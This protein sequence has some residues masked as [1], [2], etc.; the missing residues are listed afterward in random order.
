MCHEEYVINWLGKFIANIVYFGILREKRKGR[1]EKNKGE[2]REEN[3]K[4]RKGNG[5]RK[6]GKDKGQKAM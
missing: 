1:K 2:G 3:E 4:Q 5:E 6:N